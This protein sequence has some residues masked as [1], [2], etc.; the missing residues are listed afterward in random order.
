MSDEAHATFGSINIR[1]CQIRK[2]K[3]H[4]SIEKN[5]YGVRSYPRFFFVRVAGM[6]AVLVSETVVFFDVE[7]VVARAAKGL[8]VLFHCR[9]SWEPFSAV[10]ASLKNNENSGKI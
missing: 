5:A 9:A 10:C 1:K 4:K 2:K 7:G 8:L 3:L 6:A